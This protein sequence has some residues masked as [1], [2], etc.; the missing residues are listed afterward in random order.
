[1]S[2]PKWILYEWEMDNIDNYVRTTI[3]LMRE[4]DEDARDVSFEGLNLD[5]QEHLDWTVSPWGEKVYGWEY[6]GTRVGV[7]WRNDG[8]NYPAFTNSLPALCH[9]LFHVVYWRKYL[10][11]GHERFNR[12][13]IDKIN[14]MLPRIVLSPETLDLARSYQ[15]E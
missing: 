15:E 11:E 14:S 6:A 13:V 7:A 4:F 2:Y 5:I 3:N 12:D 10:S 1:M 9:E 8:Y